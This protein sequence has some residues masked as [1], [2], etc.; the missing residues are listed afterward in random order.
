MAELVPITPR[1]A[2]RIDA[3][4]PAAID[5]VRRLESLARGLPQVA[6]E[7]GHALH[8]GLYARTVR[9]PAGVVITGVLVKIATLLVVD[10]D[11][12]VHVDDGPPLRLQGHHVLPAQAGRKQAFFAQADTHIT[13]IFASGAT[14]VAEAEQ[15]FTDEADLLVSRRDAGSNRI[16]NTGE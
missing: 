11:V 16:V 15:E 5:Q 6:I 2:A 1:I 9:V 7:T 12:L 10:G 4:S 8:A 14:G 13:M 3:M